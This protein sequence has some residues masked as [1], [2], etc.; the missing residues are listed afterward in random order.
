MYAITLLN[1]AKESN[2][3]FTWFAMATFAML[4]SSKFPIVTWVGS[5][6]VLMKLTT[7]AKV[8]KFTQNVKKSNE[9]VLV[10]QDVIRIGMTYFSLVF[11]YMGTLQ[12]L[13]MTL[14]R[15]LHMPTLL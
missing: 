10:K 15:K 5:Y 4:C 8:S 2:K 9:H 7:I 3:A 6:D 14:K 13:L 11:P 12:S 1:K